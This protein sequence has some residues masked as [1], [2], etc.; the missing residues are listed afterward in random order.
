M[1]LKKWISRFFAAVFGLALQNL[2][3]GFTYE[4]IG[5]SHDIGRLPPGIG[6]AVD[7]GGRTLHLHCSAEG[8]Q[9]SFWTRAATRLDT[10][11]RRY[12]LELRPSPVR[13][14]TIAQAWDGATRRSRQEPAQPSSAIST[15]R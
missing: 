1:R 10:R 11:G 5:R 6:Q 12:R 14:G 2:L 9:R 4:Q 13:A 8:V 7:V 3:T 15:K